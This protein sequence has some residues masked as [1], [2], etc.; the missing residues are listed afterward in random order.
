MS[1]SG[2]NSNKTQNCIDQFTE[3][4]MAYLPNLMKRV[5]SSL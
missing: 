3:I 2:Q 1:Y 4:A 5:L